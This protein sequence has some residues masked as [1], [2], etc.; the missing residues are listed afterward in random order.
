MRD[1][2]DA[3]DTARFPTSSYGSGTDANGDNSGENRCVNIANH[4]AS[5][6]AKQEDTAHAQ[7]NEQNQKNATALNDV[8]WGIFPGNYERYLYQYI[9]DAASHKSGTGYWRVGDTSQP[10]GRFARGFDH[11]KGKDSMFFNI[12]D[13]LFNVFPPA[14]SQ[15]VQLHIVYY[16]ENNS[17]WK[18]MFDALGGLG[19]PAMQD[20]FIHTDGTSNKWLDITV[21]V[22]GY[23]G[24]RGPHGSDLM[25][26]NTDNKDDKFHLIEIIK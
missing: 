4:F 6:G 10:Y 13:S 5:Y 25:L 2:L 7:G 12:D 19:V 20:L 17:S 16:D 9:S 24:N 3:A 18:I 15:T 8:G 22:T 21:S 14:A 23:F 1:G 26:V 11:S